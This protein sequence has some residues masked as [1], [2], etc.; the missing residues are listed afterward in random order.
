MDIKYIFIELINSISKYDYKENFTKEIN[1]CLKYIET[2]IYN[3]KEF[4][5]KEINDDFIKDLI[6]KGYY[7][8]ISNSESNIFELI[9]ILKYIIGGNIYENYEKNIK[10]KSIEYCLNKEKKVDNYAILFSNI[11]KT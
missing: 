10:K 2:H 3:P 11:Y 5:E 4:F 6:K 8:E 1:K 7:R 9:S